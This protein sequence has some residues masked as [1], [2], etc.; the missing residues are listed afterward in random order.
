MTI[1]IIDNVENMMG[2]GENAGHKH[3]LLFP[4]HFPK[5]S[6]CVMKDKYQSMIYTA[7][8]FVISSQN[9]IEF[10]SSI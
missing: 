2:K 5:P 10:F 6:Y 9:N 3:F 1:S 7:N 8:S 4:L